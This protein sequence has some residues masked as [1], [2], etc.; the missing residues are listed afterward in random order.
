[1]KRCTKNTKGTTGMSATATCSTVGRT[2]YFCSANATSQLP[3]QRAVGIT[4]ISTF[5]HNESEFGF[6][7]F[8]DDRARP[9]RSIL[10]SFAGSEDEVAHQQPH[11]NRLAQREHDLGGATDHEIFRDQYLPETGGDSRDRRHNRKTLR[12][13][14]TPPG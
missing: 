11:R 10:G 9:D 2:K 5:S 8:L 6:M 12:R 14:T 4:G 7:L 3:T 13:R 1:M